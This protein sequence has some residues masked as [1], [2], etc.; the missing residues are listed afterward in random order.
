MPNPMNSSIDGV[1]VRFAA[2]RFLR[3]LPLTILL[4]AFMGC[5][6]SP[7]VATNTLLDSQ[8]KSFIV[9]GYSTSYAWPICYRI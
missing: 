9:I 1:K 5:A 8:E 3:F 6:Q 7:Q 4:I 2:A